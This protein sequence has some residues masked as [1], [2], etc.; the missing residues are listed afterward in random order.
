M[1]RGSTSD[2]TQQV[3][4]GSAVATVVLAIIVLVAGSIASAAAAQQLGSSSGGSPAAGGFVVDTRNRADVVAMFHRIYMVS[5]GAEERI[6]WTGSSSACDAGRVSDAFLE[7]VRRRIN[8]FRAMA[9]VSS[10]V[11]LDPMKNAKAQEA[12]LL[13]SVN[14][15]LSHYPKRDF[16]RWKCLTDDADEAARNSNAGL[17]WG[18][19]GA[20]VVDDFM[21]DAGRNNAPVGHRRWLL[22][23][24]TVEMGVGIV[25]G[26]YGAGRPAGRAIWVIGDWA[27]AGSDE[28][29]TVSWP[30]A[31]FVPYTVV[32]PRWSLSMRGANFSGAGVSM[33]VGGEEVAVRIEWASGRDG[34]IVWRPEGETTQKP[35]EDTRYRITISDFLVGEVRQSVTYAV[36]VIDPFTL[37]DAVELTGSLVP[38]VGRP[39]RYGF[40][41][42]EGATGYEF[43]YLELKSGFRSEGAEGG[44]AGTGGYIDETSVDYE[45]A[46]SEVVRTGEHAFY[47]TFPSFE[48]GEQTIELAR[49][50]VPSRDSELEFYSRFRF[51]TSTSRIV[52][53]VSVDEGRSWS[54][55]VARAG[56]GSRSSSGW[57]KE[58]VRSG[59]SLAEFAGK[60]IRVRV[61]YGRDGSAFL[62]QDGSQGVFVDDIGVTNASEMVGEGVVGISGAAK[63]VNFVPA[64]AGVFY[65]QMRPVLGRHPFSYGSAL[66]VR[67]AG[68]V[69]LPMLGTAQ[70]GGAAQGTAQSEGL[71][72]QL[73]AWLDRDFSPVHADE[74]GWTDLHYAAALDLPLMA[75]RLLNA[76][77]AVNAR[78]YVD[79][80][81]LSADL[82][83][84]LERLGLN[85][86]G[87]WNRQGETPLHMAA[88]AGSGAA[89]SVLLQHGAD[90]N[91]TTSGGTTALHY[92]SYAGA[93]AT[94]RELLGRGAS[95][96]ARGGGNTTPLH[97]ATLGNRPE[98]VA[99]L[100]N[101]GADVDAEERNGRSPL[102]VAM[103]REWEQYG[104]AP[105]GWNES[106]RRNA[107]AVIAELLRAGADVGSRGRQNQTPLHMAAY[108]NIPELA[109]LALDR[110]ADVDAIDEQGRT[111]LHVTS[112]S[113]VMALLLDEGANVNLAAGSG[114]VGRGS[115]TPLH[116]AVA[117]G[118][119]VEIVRLLLDRGA[120][121][122]AKDGDG[123]TPL[124]LAGEA[125]L[126]RLLLDRGADPNARDDAG[127]TPLHSVSVSG[128]REPSA[129]VTELLKG[130]ADLH[131]ED[132]RGCMPIHR[133]ETVAYAVALLDRGSDV[134]AATCG[135]LTPLQIVVDRM[136]GGPEET[137]SELVDELLK[138][139][140]D[141]N[142]LDEDG[143]TVLHRAARELNVGAIAE[144][145]RHGADVNATN[146]SG[147]QPVEMLRL[148]CDGTAN[149]WVAGA[150]E[151]LEDSGARRVSL[152]YPTSCP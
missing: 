119:E 61:R 52:G 4:C 46:T 84:A 120:D 51:A 75:L 54:E 102:R 118:R 43:R 90:L 65:L 24:R 140:A 108:D 39:N 12:A 9:G 97:W 105:L 56:S 64:S 5:T 48:D 26:E 31:G 137:G 78:L 69:E 40:S 35:T 21:R 58:W 74:N 134:G 144:L 68:T 25:P 83:A 138:R 70:Y 131:A 124:H 99:L 20:D 95:V 110:G 152:R 14:G 96:D 60:V 82:L 8:Y 88:V 42:I 11:V 7:D 104:I 92:A 143:N 91:A 41:R 72:D 87:G 27:E 6:G 117:N 116:T 94:A 55:V 53:E 23:P 123:E 73:R 89:A 122:D 67:A 150:M 93:V 29:A 141:I 32:Y 38:V 37:V 98:T 19:N 101:R 3:P 30:P 28:S 45:S 22:Y 149:H 15:A 63:T 59:V 85:V 17:G 57:D 113:E 81:P 10:T 133:V 47:L 76:G 109:R 62:G 106:E 33:E 44:A 126:I 107:Q 125:E 139:G 80:E 142:V 115:Y 135:G 130:G 145:I 147:R 114:Y 34:T 148:S 71:A 112:S 100:L 103:Y 77:A 2:D 121:I 127:Q 79:Q 36:T 128:V 111:P 132:Y 146:R 129:L 1:K 50:L 66:M 16:P 13:Y 18:M 136:S 151:V 86:V 49:A